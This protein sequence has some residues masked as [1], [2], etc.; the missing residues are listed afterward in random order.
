M[1]MHIY[2]YMCVCVYSYNVMVSTFFS[3]V[4]FVCDAYMIPVESLPV[5]SFRKVHQHSPNQA[6]LLTEAVIKGG[7]GQSDVA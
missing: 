7:K 6:R 1:Y 5:P 4:L 3:T 2:I